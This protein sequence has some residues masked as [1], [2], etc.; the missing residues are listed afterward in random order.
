MI[1]EDLLLLATAT[2]KSVKCCLTITELVVVWSVC[3]SVTKSKVVGP[4][5][6]LD[7]IQHFALL[8]LAVARSKKTSVSTMLLAELCEQEE[9]AQGRRS[10]ITFQTVLQ[11]TYYSLQQ[12]Q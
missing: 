3:T 2:V 8:A 9:C 10:H 1:T 7:T 6:Q 11:R 4:Q 12:Q 5:I